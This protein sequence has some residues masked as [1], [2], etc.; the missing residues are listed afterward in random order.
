[1]AGQI[2]LG[3][4]NYILDQG[5]KNTYTIGLFCNSADF[6][7]DAAILRL[8][9][10]NGYAEQSITWN[11]ASGGVKTGTVTFQHDGNGNF[12]RLAD[13]GQGYSDIYGVFVSDGTDV[14]YHVFDDAPIQ[15][16]TGYKKGRRIT[17][18]FKAS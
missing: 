5:I 6:A 9:Q 8:V 1:M 18:T 17:I 3:G 2:N 10:A 13:A 11:A 7:N 16:G 4:K 14:T 15:I 12:Y